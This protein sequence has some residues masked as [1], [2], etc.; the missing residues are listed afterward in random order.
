MR[1]CFVHPGMHLKGGTE[2]VVVWLSDVL[3]RRGHEVTVFAERYR[4]E[5][6]PREQTRNLDVRLVSCSPLTRLFGSTALRSR[7]WTKYLRRALAA[8]DVAVCQ[9]FPTYCWAV[10]ARDGAG[11]RCRI[12]WL[13]QEPCRRLHA[14]VTDAHLLDH[15]TL[16]PPG[17]DNAHMQEWA[18]ER[19]ERTWRQH[20]RDRRNLAWDVAAVGRCD[21][22]AANSRFTAEH[23]RK[24]FG[25]EAAVCHLGIPLPPEREYAPGRYAAVMTA[26]AP[27]KNVV[28]VIRALSLLAA[29]GRRDI[30]LA[31]AGQGPQRTELERLTADLGLRDVVTFRGALSDAELAGFYRDARMLIYTPVDEPFGLVPLEALAAKTPVIVS[32]HGGPAELVENGAT[33]LLANPFDPT[34]IAECIAALWDDAPR[35]RAMGEAGSRRVRE[36]FSLDA[37]ADRFLALLSS[38]AVGGRADR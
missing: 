28:N 22:V 26:L 38:Q 37:F 6:W 10:H 5:L 35:A 21:A 17:V 15:R 18:A 19:L 13:C 12:V 24:I 11:G 9:H 32:N 30:P 29:R 16:T 36:Y 8:Y 4:P 7:D 27:R 23:V 33:G 3:A 20:R 1:I 25:V 2:N 31:I 34:S 14:R